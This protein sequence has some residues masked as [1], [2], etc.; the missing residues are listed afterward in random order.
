MFSNVL[1]AINRDV[2]LK[3]FT[4]FRF[5]L[6]LHYVISFQYFTALTWRLCGIAAGIKMIPSEKHSFSA[7]RAAKPRDELRSQWSAV[8]KQMYAAGV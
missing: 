7:H 1:S 5:V 6:H 8:L 4:P 2:I 3:I